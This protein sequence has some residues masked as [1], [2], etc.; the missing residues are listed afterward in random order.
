MKIIVNNRSKLISDA[1]ALDLV[2][3]VIQ[4]GRESNDGKSYCYLSVYNYKGREIGI[5]ATVN[6]SSDRFDVWDCP[7][8][9]KQN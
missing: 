2:S 5:S 8:K 9:L 6:K 3:D 7:T 1:K 4:S